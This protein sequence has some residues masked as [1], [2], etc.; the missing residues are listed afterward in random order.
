MQQFAWLHTLPVL[1]E[2]HFAIG[3]NT[4]TDLYQI[5]ERIE[6]LNAKRSVPVRIPALSFSYGKGFTEPT[7]TRLKPHLQH[8][9]RIETSDWKDVSTDFLFKTFG[10]IEL[11]LLHENVD[12][13]HWRLTGLE[14][15]FYR[16]RTLSRNHG[17]TLS[18]DKDPQWNQPAQDDRDRW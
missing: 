7:L 1:T 8:L 14:C 6:K 13:T 12:C 10:P 3:S 2:L 17:G 15:P 9:R 16:K 5:A 11:S 4:D 18:E